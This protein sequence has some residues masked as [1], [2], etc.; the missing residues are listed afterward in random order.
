MKITFLG[1]SHGVPAA[2]RYCSC[3][4]IQTGGASYLID[5]GA[6]AIDLLLRNH[7]DPN[8]I[9][10][11]FTTHLHGD[12]VNG[13]LALTDLF[14]WHYKKTDMDVY[15]TDARG[16]AAFR[17]LL[18][19]LHCDS[20]CDDRVRFKLMTPDT[21]YEDAHIRVTPFPTQHMHAVGKPAYSYLVEADGKK[22]LFS[23]DLSQH[24]A[25]DDFPACALENEID[26]LVCE[27]AHFGPEHAEPY[28]ARCK[29]R[30]VRFTHVYPLDKL[31][32]IR[33]LDG[34]YGY[35]I[36]AVNDGDV[37]EL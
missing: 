3:T 15:L 36:C 4:L 2:D 24:L 20:L 5:A 13:V 21:V 19:A 23:G 37:I 17:E 12:H 22:A 35:P 14:T 27:M 10:A 33:A 6:P 29:A 30:D 26:L 1:T 32:K 28:L 9:R 16:I 34:R 11:L 25:K 18:G 7:V 31:E 8:S